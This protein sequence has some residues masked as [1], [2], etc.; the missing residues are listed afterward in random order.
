[1]RDYLTKL[2]YHQ[3]EPLADWV[4][5][6]LHFVSELAKAHGVKVVQVGEG[7]DEQFAG[8]SSYLQ[9]LRMYSQFWLPYS[10]WT[11]HAV[12]GFLAT[13]ARVG[14]RRYT[15]LS[16][17][18][19]IVDRAG[20]EREPFWS[21]AIGFTD[22]LKRGVSTPKLI[23]ACRPDSFLIEIGLA[24]ESYFGHDSF[25]I[26][27]HYRDEL[28]DLQ[29]NHDILQRMVNAE[30]HLRLPELLLMRVDKITMESSV[31]ARVPFLDQALVEYTSR[32]PL[33]VKL[34]NGAPKSLL[35]TAVR[36]LIPDEV[37]DRPK[38]GFGAPMADWLRGD[39]GWEAREAILSSPLL[40][41]GWLDG[42]FAEMLIDTHL[43]GKRDFGLQVWTLFNLVTW[44]EFWIE[45]A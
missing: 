24:P 38:K 21:G 15:H 39:F 5:I 36:G 6:P 31:E 34:Q 40:T 4:C 28:L 44:H 41:E 10:R 1:M 12:K 26:I 9:Y 2:V 18:F 11:P 16:M 27:E 17:Y 30:Y 45:C 33:E 3:D 37:I 20:R 8:Y 7:A 19:D 35:K 22:S 23:D 14:G 25:P 13:V 42:S 43:S 32:I 29:A